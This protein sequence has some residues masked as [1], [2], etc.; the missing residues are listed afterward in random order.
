M[1]SE[2]WRKVASGSFKDYVGILIQLRGLFWLLVANLGQK[3]RITWLLLINSIFLHLR[4][5]L[6]ASLILRG[7]RFPTSLQKEPDTLVVVPEQVKSFLD[8]PDDGN[9]PAL[10]E[11]KCALGATKDQ[12]PDEIKVYNC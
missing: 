8:Q 7:Q 12:L 9:L 5:I 1:C 6:S 10:P 2:Q 4:P 11:I 3:Y